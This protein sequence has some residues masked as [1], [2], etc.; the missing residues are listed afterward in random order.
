LADV[1]GNYAVETYSGKLLL[2]D[3]ASN[4]A[5]EATKEVT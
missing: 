1:S 4:Y 2:T 5:E 3:L